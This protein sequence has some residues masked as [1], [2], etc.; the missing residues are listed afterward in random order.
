MKIKKMG[1][2]KML[3]HLSKS[4]LLIGMCSLSSLTM[5]PK[6]SFA[7][8]PLPMVKIVNENPEVEVF[9]FDCFVSP[10]K[11]GKAIVNFKPRS[12]EE[13]LLYE[14]R[15][16]ELQKQEDSGR[17]SLLRML[18]PQKRFDEEN[19]INVIKHSLNGSESRFFIREELPVDSI[20]RKDHFV[21]GK[22]VKGIT[23]RTRPPYYEGVE[24]KLSQA[25]KQLVEANKQL[26]F[27][28]K[29]LNEQLKNK[30]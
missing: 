2:L 24:N 16:F 14:K 3:N 6:P 7:R 26:L 18:E 13:Q 30:K 23:H 1:I 10:G 28:N 4:I 9:E 5:R 22:L 15:Q 27:E 8:E 20:L 12:L 25:N 17:Y 11:I 21:K 29:L 19:R